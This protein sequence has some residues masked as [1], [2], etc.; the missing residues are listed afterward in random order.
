MPFLVDMGVTRST[1][2]MDMYNGQREN[3]EPSMGLNG[4]VTKTYKTLP[5]AVHNA[6][7]GDPMFH[8]CFRLIPG[9]RVNLLGRELI[10]KL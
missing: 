5:L 3:A 7:T 1:I 6:T 10:G 4:T 8:H 9:C 2:S